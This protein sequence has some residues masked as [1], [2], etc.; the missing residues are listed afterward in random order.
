MNSLRTVL[1][2]FIAPI[3]SW[4]LARKVPLVGYGNMIRWGGSCFF[5]LACDTEL[6][7]KQLDMGTRTVI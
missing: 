6:D 4:L 2:S 3:D 5:T 7:V 1:S